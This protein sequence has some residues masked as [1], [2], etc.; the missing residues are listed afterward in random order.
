MAATHI[1]ISYFLFCILYFVSKKYP[2]DDKESDHHDKYACDEYAFDDSAPQE[3]IESSNMGS[4]NR[5][6]YDSFL[7]VAFENGTIGIQ[8]DGVV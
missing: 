3:S 5:H 1:C 4:E 8:L 7:N 2:G 6:N